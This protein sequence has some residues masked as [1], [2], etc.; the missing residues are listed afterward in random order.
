MQTIKLKI[1]NS[2]L[3]DKFS[4]GSY[5]LN[6]LKKYYIVELSENP[7]YVLYNDSDFE[8]LKYDCIR[9][10]FT[11]ENFT[12]NFNLC[13]YAIGFD[14]LTFQD[15]FYRMPLYLIAPF[16]S[17]EE[18]GLAG[19]LSFTHQK[20]FTKEDLA[21]KTAF[22]SFVYSNY[23][24]DKEREELFYK[25]SEYKKVDSGG[26]F[27]NNVGGR[28]KNKLEF[29]MSHKFSI[30]S[31]N[32]SRSGYTTERLLNS[33]VAK[34]IPIYWGNPDIHKEFNEERF[35][36]CHRY[37]NFDEVLEVVKKI[38]QNDDLYLEMINKP[39]V[40]LNYDF[41]FV[42]KGF[43]DFLCNIFDQ[44]I[45]KAKRR[46]IN[47]A[48]LLILEKN[49]TLIKKY[50]LRKNWLKK[51]FSIFYRPFKKLKFI[52]KFKQRILV[53]RIHKK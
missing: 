5:F 1:C 31:E 16:Y 10:M 52:D 6:I 30:A 32:S 26:A 27:L 49:E 8:Y 44:P 36:N 51:L 37:K 11:G 20:S 50:L 40:A 13:D 47:T 35:I 38:D 23:L 18:L 2:N 28:V 12:P 21:Q 43:E 42:K 17:D 34:T 14:Y 4:F 3:N 9:I 41:E 45:K 46:T 19:D 24:A 53:Y 7:D 33:I 29:E 22:C 25:L 39:V 15:R 48:R